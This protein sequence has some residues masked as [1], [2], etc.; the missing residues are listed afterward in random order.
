MR[1]LCCERAAARGPG[2]QDEVEV[3]V[4]ELLEPARRWSAPW[5]RAPLYVILDGK[6]IDPDRCHEK[7]TSRKGRDIGLW[8]SGKKRP[9]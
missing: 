8:Y 3:E 4:E 1:G 9:A 6:I 5:P 2:R 7:T